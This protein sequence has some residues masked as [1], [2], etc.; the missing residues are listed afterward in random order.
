MPNLP[1]N[2]YDRL[3]V[4]KKEKIRAL[5]L[6]LQRGD[7]AH[8]LLEME[9]AIAYNKQIDSILANPKL[10]EKYKKFLRKYRNTEEVTP[11][12]ES[13]EVAT[14][15]L[16]FQE[17][18]F[19]VPSDDRE[20][21][22]LET[23]KKHPSLEKFLKFWYKV[24]A[25]KTGDVIEHLED[26][27]NEIGEIT[28][29][30]GEQLFIVDRKNS[31]EEVDRF[32]A[33]VEVV[34]WCNRE[35]V[36]QKYFLTYKKLA[37]MMDVI[38]S[39]NH[40]FYKDYQHFYTEVCMG[41]LAG[42]CG[43]DAKGCHVGKR[44]AMLLADGDFVVFSHNNWLPIYNYTSFGLSVRLLKDPKSVLPK[45]KNQESHSVV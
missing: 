26:Y 41:N 29:K 33:Y 12:M 17:D 15:F 43:P 24:K 11:K 20:E 42:Y 6:A 7:L 36:E 13:R 30:K 35:E 38:E 31:P 3:P 21:V 40:N 2:R 14:Q 32:L 34:T 45:D 25:N 19:K 28:C 1:R 27:E 39:G 18:T 5:F 8:N 37:S 10:S 23:V 16:E 9:N 22:T 4:K 44:F